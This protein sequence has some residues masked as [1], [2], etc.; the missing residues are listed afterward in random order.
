[1][2]E[3]KEFFEKAALNWHNTDDFNLVKELLSRAGVKKDSIVLDVGCGN[4]VIT[5][6]LYE[7]T[8]V[9]VKAIDFSTNMIAK[10]MDIHPE[11]DKYDF[12]CIDFYEYIA[13]N[14]Y[15]YLV[16]YNA[17][18]HFLDIK[19]LC[20]KANE[21]LKE[22]GRLVIAHGMGRG[23]LVAHHKCLN[24]HICR[25]ISDPISE[26]KAYLDYFELEKWLDND[27]CYLMVLKKR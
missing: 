7:L 18:P 17:Y 6:L 27:K 1:M 12:K 15:D 16:I 11:N 22:N 9:K 10:A 23:T 5:P 8:G 26:A 3:I 20:I 24:S 13:P 21:L 14:K 4:G 19:G 2:N 25:Q